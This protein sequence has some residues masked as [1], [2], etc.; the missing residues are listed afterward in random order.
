MAEV[1]IGKAEPAAK[2]IRPAL[3]QPLVHDG[4]PAHDRRFR[5]VLNRR[6]VPLSRREAVRIVIALHFGLDITCEVKDRREERTSQWI[7]QLIHRVFW[8][9][10]DSGLARQSG[11]K[12]YFDPLRPET[13]YYLVTCLC[14]CL[15]EYSTGSRAMK[16]CDADF[17]GRVLRREENITNTT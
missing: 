16:Y 9:K 6:V 11:T 12:K 3:C 14:W 5:H 13:I 10:A 2:C 15:M 4:Q 7:V 8:I 1:G 17:E